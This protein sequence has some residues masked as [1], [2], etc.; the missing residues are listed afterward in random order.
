MA[1]GKGEY[2]DTDPLDF[3][4]EEESARE[5]AQRRFSSPIADVTKENLVP[6]DPIIDIIDPDSEP[7]S[8]SSFIPTS[9]VSSPDSGD[10]LGI[11]SITLDDSPEVVSEDTWSEEPS[12]GSDQQEFLEANPNWRPSN[13]QPLDFQATPP[14]A[15]VPSS[16]QPSTASRSSLEYT[17]RIPTDPSSSS[18]LQPKATRESASTSKA[19]LTLTSTPRHRQSTETE[20]N[21]HSSSEPTDSPSPSSTI[22]TAS[23]SSVFYPIGQQPQRE[24]SHPNATN[25]SADNTRHDLDL[26]SGIPGTIKEEETEVDVS[27]MADDYENEIMGEALPEAGIEGRRMMPL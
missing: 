17:A 5:V 12:S 18:S 3:D 23:Q 4:V 22:P 10:D 2:R 8:T 24:P 21:F 6:P 13:Q 27:S 7:G 9:V 16:P 1:S 19:N 20:P 11:S 25:N 15:S 14:S 26:G